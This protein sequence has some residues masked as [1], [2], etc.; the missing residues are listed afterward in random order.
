[1][2]TYILIALAVVFGIYVIRKV[3]ELYFLIKLT[4]YIARGDRKKAKN[5][6]GDGIY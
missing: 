3:I 1:M 5:S 6:N 4:N 2:V